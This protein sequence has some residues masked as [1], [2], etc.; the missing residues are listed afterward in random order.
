MQN[1]KTTRLKKANYS[2][3]GAY[4]ITICTKNRR[5]I[6]SHIV[7]TGVLDGPPSSQIVGTGVLDGHFI[8]FVC[9]LFK[10]KNLAGRSVERPAFCLSYFIRLKLFCKVTVVN[11][12]VLSVSTGLLGLNGSSYI[13]NNRTVIER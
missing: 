6:L 13:D 3:P 12:L 4:F 5:S 11:V 9:T 1:R 7:G 2:G 10:A 8:Y